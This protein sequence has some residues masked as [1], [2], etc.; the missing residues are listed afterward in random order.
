MAVRRPTAQLAIGPSPLAIAYDISWAARW[1]AGSPGRIATVTQWGGPGPAMSMP[2]GSPTVSTRGVRRCARRAQHLAA[3]AG[4]ARGAGS[5]AA[6]GRD[7]TGTPGRARPLTTNHHHSDDPVPHCCHRRELARS[8]WGPARQS[9]RP[10]P[11]IIRADQVGPRMPLA[12]AA[13]APQPDPRLTRP[14][15]RSPRHAVPATARACHSPAPRRRLNQTPG[16]T[17]PLAR[18]PRHAVP[19]TSLAGDS[20]APAL[21][22]P[23]GP[24]GHH[25]RLGRTSG[26]T[27]RRAPGDHGQVGTRTLVTA[28][29]RRHVTRWPLMTSHEPCH[30]IARQLLGATRIHG[31]DSHRLNSLHR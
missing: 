11:T 27:G 6:R 9:G 25:G 26:G 2:D 31:P 1:W 5:P 14:L 10:G 23:G 3:S 22:A 12:S 19:A 21:P 13:A 20:D 15:A 18:S 30:A 29:H 24:V 8:S 16:L 17:R 7:A 4:L 28:G